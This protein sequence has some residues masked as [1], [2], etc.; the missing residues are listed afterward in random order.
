MVSAHLAA[1][2]EPIKSR[3][4]FEEPGELE[5]WGAPQGLWS[6]EE[7]PQAER[8]S[9]DVKTELFCSPPWVR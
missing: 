2:V 1:H 4:G 8:S 9:T 7:P 6:P 3:P 5:A